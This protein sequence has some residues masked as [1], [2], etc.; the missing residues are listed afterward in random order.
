MD[1]EPRLSMAC[2]TERKHR[3]SG[4]YERADDW[5]S[6]CQ[7]WYY[8]TS[9]KPIGFVACRCGGHPENMPKPAKGKL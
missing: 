3:R 2:S 8:E 7:G 4:R 6:G 5:H 9:R 1:D